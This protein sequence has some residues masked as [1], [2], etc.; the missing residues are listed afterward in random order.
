MIQVSARNLSHSSK[1]RETESGTQPRDQNDPSIASKLEP[2]M[3][4][5]FAHYLA[6][7]RLLPG[8]I[9]G[10]A[11]FHSDLQ[12]LLRQHEALLKPFCAL[13]NQT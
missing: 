10:I 4:L 3:K 11:R 8:F 1:R 13:L 2:N 9:P 7:F 5:L 6:S 12:S